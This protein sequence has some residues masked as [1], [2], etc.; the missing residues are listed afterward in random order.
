MAHFARAVH[1]HRPFQA[2][3]AFSMGNKTPSRR[4]AMRP[5]VNMSKED[6]ATDIGSTHKK[7][8]KDRACG[9]GDILTDRQTDRQTNRQTNPHTDIFITIGLLR[10][11][12]RG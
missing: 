11:R 2:D 8:G 9:S 12:S 4:Q 1:S 6:P 7:V 5:I 10:N 3:N